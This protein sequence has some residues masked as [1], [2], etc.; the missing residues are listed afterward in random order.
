MTISE[1]S[2]NE[3]Y[4]TVSEAALDVTMVGGHSAMEIE[5]PLWEL[6]VSV[7][8]LSIVTCFT[9]VGNA[10]VI[11]SV[12]SYRPL[13]IVPNYFIVSL[14]VADL[15]MA[16]FVLLLGAAN[17]IMGKWVFGD[18]LCRAW[19]TIDILCCTASILNLCAIALDRYWAI[20]DAINYA[21]K[22]TAP[23]VLFMIGV[24]W[25][26]SIVICLP[27][28][29]GWNN[30]EGSTPKEPCTPT[31][32]KGYVIFSAIGSFYCPL[33]IMII[34]NV[35]I[36][37][38]IRKR[39]RKRVSRQSQILDL[40]SARFSRLEAVTPAMLHA[41]PRR[42]HTL[43]EYYRK[44][45]DSDTL[46]TKASQRR[47]STV[48]RDDNEVFQVIRRT[49]KISLTKERRAART[50]GTV[51][52]AFVVCWLPFFL[53]YVI[54]P[55]CPSCTSP[56]RKVQNFIIWLG[57]LNSAFN[58]VIYTFFNKDFCNAVAKVLRRSVKWIHVCGHAEVNP[59]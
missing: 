22:R 46:P 3:T 54:L 49:G 24:V 11:V 43:T 30:W 25:T 50:L 40:P 57:Y 51:M 15:T 42:V 5:L 16:V 18:C 36:F 23:R 44:R 10:L 56:S 2:V 33:L 39:L 21:Q 28:I 7:V 31:N 38:S 9:F 45:S 12:L 19:L 47:A 13:R 32:D 14:A 53:M 58:P 29:F 37:R 26:M 48:M 35:K 6:V 8:S 20:S 1:P 34:L 52:G 27:P 59:V 41:P 17:T 55:F 4:V